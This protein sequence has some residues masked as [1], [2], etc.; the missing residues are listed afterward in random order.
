MADEIL[1]KRRLLECPKPRSLQQQDW[2]S[3]TS[4]STNIRI[5]S[6]SRATRS[7]ADHENRIYPQSN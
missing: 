2:P 3:A 7:H 6:Q 4:A 1:W 5:Q